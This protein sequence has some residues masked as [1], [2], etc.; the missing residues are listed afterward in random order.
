MRRLIS[1]RD[2]RFFRVSRFRC[3]ALGLDGLA[4][5]QIGIEA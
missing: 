1:Q 4:Q 5:G 3:R 2:G